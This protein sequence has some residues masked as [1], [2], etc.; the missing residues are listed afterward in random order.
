MSLNPRVKDDLPAPHLRLG[1]GAKYDHPVKSFEQTREGWKLETRKP[2]SAPDWITSRL[3]IVCDDF[4][5]E[6][7]EHEYHILDCGDYRGG[8]DERRAT[9]I[10]LHE[11]LDIK[12]ARALLGYAKHWGC[13]SLSHR[14]AKQELLG[15]RWNLSEYLPEEVWRKFEI[16]WGWKDFGIGYIPQDR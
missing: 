8:F 10:L 14:D 1:G 13:A 11:G 9:E 2:T 4:A 7:R 15:D 3:V 12:Q 6:P 16:G 5:E